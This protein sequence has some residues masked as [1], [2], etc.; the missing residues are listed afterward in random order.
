MKD[1][2]LVEY[3]FIYT[4]V[5]IHEDVF[6]LLPS[7]TPSVF[8]LI[9]CFLLSSCAL[10]SLLLSPDSVILL[11][12]SPRIPSLV[13]FDFFHLLPNPY[14][15]FSPCPIV[16]SLNSLHLFLLL[17]P[18]SLPPPPSL[19]SRLPLVSMLSVCVGVFSPG[20]CQVMFCPIAPSVRSIS[21][22]R[23]LEECLGSALF[24]VV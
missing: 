15:Y 16:T 11:P 19:L 6:H 13:R 23:K 24:C 14:F 3:A 4:A 21:Q 8:C 20:G 7:V 18:S 22:G 12:L 10:V 9:L 5:C 1:K 17:S 2:K